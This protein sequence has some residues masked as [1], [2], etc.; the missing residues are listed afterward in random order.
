MKIAF[1][2]PLDGWHG[3]GANPTS[4]E[5]FFS[6]W[7]HLWRTR[8]NLWK[9]GVVFNQHPT[10]NC[11]FNGRL[12]LPAW[13]TF[14][15]GGA[16]L[17]GKMAFVSTWV[18][19]WGKE[20][21]S[22]HLVLTTQSKV[23]RTIYHSFALWKWVF[24]HVPNYS[25][26]LTTC[27]VLSVLHGTCPYCPPNG[28]LGLAGPPFFLKKGPL[29]MANSKTHIMKLWKCQNKMIKIVQCI[30]SKHHIETRM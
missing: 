3:L 11:S 22:K 30:M 21:V 13:S 20:R 1:S 4:E 26:S 23:V 29:S 16:Y 28:R 19:I 14:N 7:P 15:N 12:Q 24:I 25:L 5:F 27:S 18:L 6:A 17:R 10:L 8:C 2:R 9:I